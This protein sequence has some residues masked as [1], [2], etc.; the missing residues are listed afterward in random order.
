MIVIDPADESEGEVVI[1]EAAESA[2][3]TR[4][5]L[6]AQITRMENA[7]A[8]KE[9]ELEETRSELAKVCERLDQHEAEREGFMMLYQASSDVYAVLCVDENGNVTGVADGYR[10]AQ[11]VCALYNALVRVE[12]DGAVGE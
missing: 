9:A 2:L 5:S 6:L 3:I 10:A 11:S 1:S 12:T 7:L 8:A 4:R